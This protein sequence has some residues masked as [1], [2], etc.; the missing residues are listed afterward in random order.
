M[1]VKFNPFN[2]II[3]PAASSPFSEILKRGLAGRFWDAFEIFRGRHKYYG[4]WRLGLVDYCTGGLLALLEL[5]AR[6]IID[7]HDDKSPLGYKI[8]YQVP[9][10]VLLCIS[11]LIRTVFA[12]AM[13]LL[14][15]PVIFFVHVIASVAA[16]KD[17]EA[18]S[19]LIVHEEME[20]GYSSYLS[21]GSI[22]ILSKDCN[23][24]LDGSQ[25]DGHSAFYNDKTEEFGFDSGINKHDATCYF[26]RK[27]GPLKDAPDQKA[28]Y[29]AMIRLNLFGVAQRME[30]IHPHVTPQCKT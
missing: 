28:A 14:F 19:K 12:V 11:V 6:K 21:L 9:A 18:A 22:D 15:S 27:G 13:T 16:K 23:T 10:M 20:H 3:A 1:K 2:I 25:T 17:F 26:A 5:P 29:A 24:I 30:E 4:I 8:L 7:S